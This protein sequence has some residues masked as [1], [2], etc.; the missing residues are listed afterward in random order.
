MRWFDASCDITT[1][2]NV[3][4]VHHRLHTWRRLLPTADSEWLLETAPKSVESV[5]LLELE[6]AVT[7]VLIFAIQIQDKSYF[8]VLIKII[9]QLII[10]TIH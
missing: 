4:L 7:G 3:C 8:H 6:D 5:V 1:F 10:S 9:F 2:Q